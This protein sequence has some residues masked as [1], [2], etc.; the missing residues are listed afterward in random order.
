MYRY[1]ETPGN[2]TAVSTLPSLLALVVLYLTLLAPRVDNY[3]LYL[4]VALGIWIATTF[5]VSPQTVIRLPLAYLLFLFWVL[6]VV[7]LPSA[8]S[9]DAVKLTTGVGLA[10]GPIIMYDTLLGGATSASQRRRNAFTLFV[11]LAPMVLWLIAVNI[12]YL[13]QN[14]M[15]A[16]Y[17]T[18]DQYFDAHLVGA[19][20]PVAMGGG[21][22]FIY[23]VLLLS[24]VAM[25]LARRD[26]LRVFERALLV[27]LSL[28]VLILV[29]MANFATAFLVCAVTTAIS[30]FG[31]SSSRISLASYAVAASLVLSG[32]LL[33]RQFLSS[34]IVGVAAFFPSGSVIGRR[35]DELSELLVQS[36]RT[37]SVGFRFDS[38]L[39]SLSSFLDSPLFGQAYLVGFNFARESAHV[40]QHS[41]WI[42]TLARYGIIGSFFLLGFIYAALRRLHA[43]HAGS[44]H[45]RLIV[46]PILAIVVLGFANPI[47]GS[48]ALVF[49]FVLIPS[50]IIIFGGACTN[51]EISSSLGLERIRLPV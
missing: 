5:A 12:Y 46:V 42:D 43:A 22:D 20:L 2:V 15:L 48:S 10:L 16:R 36:V 35:L 14:P 45:Q 18:S 25:Y 32:L 29:Y 6:L 1:L 44:E 30:L 17:L 28:L 11:G 3:W 47:L 24:P 37:T 31:R 7:V 34:A 23:G 39:L 13:A 50:A 21:F 8:G 40:G 9:D 19:G 41:E 49:M 51:F 4:A 26:G 33:A 38:A 27:A